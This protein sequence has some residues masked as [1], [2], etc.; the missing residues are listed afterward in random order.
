V[1]VKVATVK[2]T[3]G[4]SFMGKFGFTR[5]WKPSAEGCFAGGGKEGAFGL[6]A[7]LPEDWLSFG[8]KLPRAPVSG[9][10]PPEFTA[11]FKAT[12]FALAD[13]FLAAFFLELEESEL[14][15][16]RPF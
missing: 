16:R 6:G 9:G 1:F 15:C 12:F 5:I 13:A 7:V 4:R 2:A 8:G 14:S 10:L 11:S 3:M